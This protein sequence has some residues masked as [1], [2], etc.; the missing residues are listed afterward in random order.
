ME[1]D[2]SSAVLL[3]SKAS[4]FLIKAVYHEFQ[5]CKQDI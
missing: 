3:K 1:Q 2:N 5:Q 4:A